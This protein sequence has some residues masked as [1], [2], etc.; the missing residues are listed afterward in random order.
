MAVPAWAN[1]YA[2]TDSPEVC[3]NVTHFCGTVITVP[4]GVAHENIGEN[5]V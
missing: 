1:W 5:H 2:R 3:R 4:Y